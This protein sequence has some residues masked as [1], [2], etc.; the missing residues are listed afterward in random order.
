MNRGQRNEILAAALVLAATAGYQKLTREAVANQAGCSPAQVSRLF[1]TMS[2]FRRAVM[3]YAISMQ[4]L[5]VIAQGL[6]VSDPR[7]R[8]AAADLRARALEAL[9]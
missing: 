6:A 7:A 4:C 8:A 2:Q 5:P 3:G 1:G 9:Q